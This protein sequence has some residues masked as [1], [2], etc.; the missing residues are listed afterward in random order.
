MNQP[1]IAPIVMSEKTRSYRKLWLTLFSVIALS[2]IALGYFGREIYTRLHR[3][4]N[5]SSPLT[6][7]RYSLGR[8]LR[9]VRTSGNPSVARKS[10]RFGATALMSHP[11]GRRI[12]AHFLRY[13]TIC[14]TNS[15]AA[16]EICGRFWQLFVRCIIPKNH[17]PKFRRS[18]APN[19]AGESTVT[20]LPFT[21]IS[22]CFRNFASVREKVSLTVPSSAASTRLVTVS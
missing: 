3:S 4:Q 2:F 16:C 6:A 5:K 9:T 17:S 19:F 15:A 13:Q 14:Q 1:E 18:N 22:F 11:I 12:G 7:K 21:V 20:A 8:T 10:A